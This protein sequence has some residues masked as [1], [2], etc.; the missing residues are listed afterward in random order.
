VT[1]GG[2]VP[3][4]PPTLVGRLERLIFTHRTAILVLFALGTVVLGATA[5]R[6]LRIDTSFNTTSTCAPIWTRGWRN[7]VARI[8]C[9]S[10]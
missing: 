7:S 5:V 3:H 10:H 9:W 1:T 2:D 8:A 4:L 6:G